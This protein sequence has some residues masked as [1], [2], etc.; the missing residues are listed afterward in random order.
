MKVWAFVPAR[1]GSKSIVLKNLLLLAGK[2]LMQ[3][4]VEAAK[5]SGVFDRIVVSTEHEKI[6]SLAKRLQVEVDIRPEHLCQDD[7]AVAD[8]AV[9]FLS[10]QENL[11][12]ILA[13][14]QPTSP[15]LRPEDINQAINI[16]AN[17]PSALSVQTVARCPHNH[18]A[19]NQR[20]IDGGQ[21]RFQ[22]QEERNSAYNKQKKPKFFVFGNFIAIRPNALLDGRGFFAT[23]SLALEIPRPYDFDL[24]VWEDV[25]LAEALLEKNIVSLN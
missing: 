15:F 24:D 9:D 3:Y 16:L 10:R 4:G 14:V 17:S 23:P 20:V 13:L 6:I 18:H 19:W 25:V 21:V 12:D 5:R 8:V 1:G 22:F 7:S 2:P 11:P